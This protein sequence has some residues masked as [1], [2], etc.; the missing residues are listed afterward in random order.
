MSEHIFKAD[1]RYYKG[2]RMQY[3]RNLSDVFTDIKHYKIEIREKNWYKSESNSHLSIKALDE[4]MNMLADNV[5][6]SIPK[7]NLNK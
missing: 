4:S 1:N 7:R 6:K 3:D 5:L 2:S